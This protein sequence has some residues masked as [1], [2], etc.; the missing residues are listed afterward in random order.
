MSGYTLFPLHTVSYCPSLYDIFSEHWSAL[1]NYKNCV[2]MIKEPVWSGR[3]YS[4][5]LML[6]RTCAAPSTAQPPLHSLVL[7]CTL[8]FPVGFLIPLP[9]A[10]LTHGYTV[11]VVVIR[12]R[13]S[14]FTSKTSVFRNTGC[15]EVGYIWKSP[16]GS[17]FTLSS[18]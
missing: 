6:Q 15:S 16:W 1:C 4:V 7:H 5:L 17:S 11:T 12:R 2:V 10:R 8:W 14:I 3:R 13:L 9:P 18:R